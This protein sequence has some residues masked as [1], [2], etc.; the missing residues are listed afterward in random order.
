LEEEIESKTGQE[1][2]ELGWDA[3]FILAPTLI[4]PASKKTFQKYRQNPGEMA[5]TET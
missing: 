4:T 2:K 3:V 1:N 5:A